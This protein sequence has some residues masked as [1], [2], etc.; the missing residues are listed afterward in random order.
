[1]KV[2]T[3]G[4]LI[5]AW[6]SVLDT[7]SCALDIGCGTGLIALMLAQRSH[8]M[9][10]AVD[11]DADSATQAMENTNQ[12]S[13]SERI[14]IK[15]INIVDLNQNNIYDLIVS[16]PPFFSDSLLPPDKGR[17]IARHTTTLTFIDLV[18]SVHRLLS[19]TGRFSLILP[20]QESASF[21]K[22]AQGK[23]YLSRRCNVSSRVGSEVK[24]VMSEY[25]LTK[26]AEP[27]LE[28]LSIREAGS[29]DYT[30]EYKTLTADFYL[31][32]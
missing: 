26:S 2:G 27:D 8:A 14:N 24:R 25:R 29:D 17:T 28:K 31:K 7:D 21:E 16:N 4:V 13:W 19:P 3:D 5:G 10:D 20:P 32:F 12:S 22:V 30:A 6:A 11:I 23:L 9:I 1:M 15:N 18:D